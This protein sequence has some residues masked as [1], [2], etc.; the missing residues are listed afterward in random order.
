[1]AGGFKVLGE[2][3]QVQCIKPSDGVNGNEY[4]AVLGGTRRRA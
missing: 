4:H 3:Y 2:L 1:M